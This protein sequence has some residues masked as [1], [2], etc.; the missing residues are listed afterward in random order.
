MI[1]EEYGPEVVHVKGEHNVVADAL[2]CLDMEPNPEDELPTK[3]E[4]NQLEYAYVNSTDIKME[5]FPMSPR[6]LNKQQQK[7]KQLQKLF[8]EDIKKEHYS[9]DYVEGY[10]LIHYKGKICVP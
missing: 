7:D 3:E 9:T 4:R 8:K 5:Q 10:E 2:S 1:L 6:L